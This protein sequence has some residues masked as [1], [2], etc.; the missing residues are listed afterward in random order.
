MFAAYAQDSMVTR[1]MTWRPHTSPSEA[2][3]VIEGF[4]ARWQARTEFCWLIFTRATAELIG[5]IG[6]GREDRGF[7]LGFVLARSWWGHGL[8]P[9][10]ITVVTQWAFSEPSV[11]RVWAACDIEN[12]DLY[13]RCD[14]RWNFHDIQRRAEQEHRRLVIPRSI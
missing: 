7:N 5:S 12:Q 2:H 9:E 4:L 14:K 10:A 8:M 11:S 13:S 1:Y 3:A 6:A